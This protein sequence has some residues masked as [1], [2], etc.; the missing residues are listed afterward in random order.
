MRQAVLRRALH[1]VAG[2][3]GAFP[4]F[5]FA[6]QGLAQPDVG[7]L[8]LHVGYVEGSTPLHA[9]REVREEFAVQRLCRLEA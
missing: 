5:L 6:R 7:E 3:L 1:R 2:A 9:R 8:L 4:Q